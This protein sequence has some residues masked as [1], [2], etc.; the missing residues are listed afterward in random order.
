MQKRSWWRVWAIAVC[1]VWLGATT[2]ALAQPRQKVTFALGGDG[3]HMSLIHLA[4]KGGFMAQEGLEGEIID[5]GTNARQAAAVMGG[6]VDFA[7]MGLIQVI[8]AHLQGGNMITVAMLFDTLDISVVLSTEAIAKAG[9]TPGM[10]IDE[11]V[12][13]MQ[14]M[15]IAITSAGSTTDTVVR[16]LLKKRGLDPDKVVTIQPIGSGATMLA[17]LEKKQTDGFAASAPHVQSAELK[18]VGRIIVDPFS[19]E[20]PEMVGVPYLVLNTSKDTLKNRPQ[21]VRS[22]VR[23]MTRAMRFAA[24]QPAEARAIL[25]K[26]FPDLDEAT[27]N[28][29]WTR[30]SKGIPKSPVVSPEKIDKTIEWLNITTSPPVVV[31]YEGVANA[32]AA[33]PAEAELLKN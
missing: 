22:T 1:A 4:M 25:R 27:F 29:I 2:S 26:H 24:E 9:I 8:K 18:G 11:R 31:K 13:R 10:S 28:A 7:P 5:V 14:G 20:A 23:A 19:G 21:L 6:S 17:A 3:F 15:K 16:S 12:R 33:R 32:D 30:Y